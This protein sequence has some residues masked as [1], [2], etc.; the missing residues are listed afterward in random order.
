MNEESFSNQ[1]PLPLFKVN[2]LRTYFFTDEGVVKAVD[3]VDLE[4]QQGEIFGL[5]GESGCGKSVTALS[6]LRLIEHPGRIVEGKVWYRDIQLLEI[7]EKEMMSLCGKSIS[8]IF[9]QPLSS[10]DPVIPIGAQVAEVFRAHQVMKK[11][12]AWKRS[13]ELLKLVGFPASEK[14]ALAY[15]HQ[16]S[17]GQAQ[18][19]MIAMALALNPEILIAD[20]PTTALDVTIQAQILDLL[21]DLIRRTGT[22]VIL[23]TH[24]LGVIAE[25]ANRVGVMYAG[26]IVE[27]AEVGTLFVKPLHP[28]TKALMAS[29]PI[30]GEVKDRLEVIPGIVPDLIN[31][32]PGCRFASRCKA[33]E[34]FDLKICIREEPSL[35]EFDADHPV[36]CW[37]YEDS[38]QHQAPMG[39]QNR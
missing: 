25:M 35:V 32:P 2:G 13:I 37:L 6:L 24:D 31:L 23:I 22:A 17:G 34:E 7:T 12:E 3:G 21:R 39:K 19:V 15:P 27:Q 8:M 26:S 29:M 14:L 33:M 36:R 5:V 30:L 16:I 1:A 11:S 10:L 38:E 4:V 28:Y 20:E 18:R 9:Q